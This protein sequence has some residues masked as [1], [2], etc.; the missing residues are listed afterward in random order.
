MTELSEQLDELHNHTRYAQTLGIMLHDLL[1]DDDEIQD[2]DVND[3]ASRT[4][5][6]F[7]VLE[8]LQ[9]KVEAIERLH[10]K[11]RSGGRKSQVAS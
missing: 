11:I 7:I 4:Q 2:A 1:C 10:E 9:E 8:T 5:R 3:P 6:L